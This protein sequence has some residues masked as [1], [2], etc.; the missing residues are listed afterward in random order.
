MRWQT[1]QPASLSSNKLYD[2][3]TKNGLTVRELA[4]LAGIT[5]AMVSNFENNKQIP[6]KRVLEKLAKAFNVPEEELFKEIES[7]SKDKSV[8]SSPYFDL[9]KEAESIKSEGARELISSI[10]RYCLSQ[11]EK[12]QVLRTI[13]D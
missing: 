10:I 1:F 11:E 5:H 13:V 7:N 8:V 2:L 3:R 12:M 4:S 9:L 6:G